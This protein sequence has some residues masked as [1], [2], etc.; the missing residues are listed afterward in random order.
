MI[1][2]LRLADVPALLLFLGKSP[3]NEARA[4]GR[5]NDGGREL[6]TLFPIIKGCLV[7]QDTEHSY[8]CVRRAAIL[9]LACLQSCR[10]RSAWELGRLYLAPGHQECSLD[11]LE[12][13]GATGDE[14]GAG[15]IFLRLR[16]DSALVDTARQAGFNQYLTEILYRLGDERRAELPSHSLAVRPKSIED[17]YQVFR[18]YSSVVPLQVRTVEGMTFEEWSQS[19]DRGEIKELVMVDKGEVKAWLRIRHD[20]SAGQFDILT[21]LDSGDIGSLVDYSIAALRGRSPLYCLVSEFQQHYRHVLE[22]RGFRQEA[23]FSCLSKQLVVR[24]REPQLV[25][26]SA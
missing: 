13:L 4:R 25:P 2:S 22:E 9:G 3:V 7:S 18:L 15:R 8:I 6:V 21:D 5:L 14:L 1:R 17:D 16:A 20:G 19:R 11:L 12:R 26:L 23:E 10:G 24:V